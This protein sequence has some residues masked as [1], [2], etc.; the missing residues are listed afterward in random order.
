MKIPK[1][2]KNART[3]LFRHGINSKDAKKL[4]PEQIEIL[5]LADGFRRESYRPIAL[6][7]QLTKIT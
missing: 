1:A 3:D 2:K 6:I 5:E 4:T 7:K